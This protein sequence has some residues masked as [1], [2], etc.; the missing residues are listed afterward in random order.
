MAARIHYQ[1][2]ETMF[3]HLFAPFDHKVYQNPSVIERNFIKKSVGWKN[4]NGGNFWNKIFEFKFKF[5]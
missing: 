3:Y 5:S 4:K 2:L 1:S